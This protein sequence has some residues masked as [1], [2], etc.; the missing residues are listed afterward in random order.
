M[1]GSTRIPDPARLFIAFDVPSEVKSAIQNVQRHLRDIR[2]AGV[3]WARPEGIHLT[4][5]FLGDVARSE[6]ALVADAVQKASEGVGPIQF[7]ATGFGG[8]PNLNRPKVLWLGL[9]SQGELERLV[10]QINAEL[11]GIGFEPEPKPFTAHLT[12]GRVKFIDPGSDLVSRLKS[13][14]APRA[15]WDTDRVQLMMSDLRPTGAVYSTL[16]SV[17]LSNPFPTLSTR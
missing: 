10:R 9:T 11:A 2:T 3:S 7:E 12:I 13:I 16:H 14:P 17:K 5:K 8:F 1:D 4:L 6:I 15:E